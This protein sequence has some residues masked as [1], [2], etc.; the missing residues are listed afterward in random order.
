MGIVDRV[1]RNAVYLFSSNVLCRILS[2]LFFLV[3]SQKLV[4]S[5]FGK[6][7]LVLTVTSYFVILGNLGFQPMSIKEIS[8]N[9]ERARFIFLNII[10]IRFIFSLLGLVVFFIMI[11]LFNYDSEINRYFYIIAFTV[12]LTPMSDAMTAMFFAHEKM[13]APALLGVGFSILFNLTGLVVIFFEGDSSLEHLFFLSLAVGIL[14]ISGYYLLFRK[15]F[16]PIRPMLDR[17]FAV[18]IIKRTLPFG[19]L[20]FLAVIH[21]RIDI[22]MLSKIPA[23]DALDPV[24]MGLEKAPGTMSAVAYYA[25]PYKLFN[26]ASMLLDSVRLVIYPVISAHFMKSFDIV[27][28]TYYKL[29]RLTVYFFSIPLFFVAFFGSSYLITTIFSDKWGPSAHAMKILAGVFALN[30]LNI[31]VLPI[32]LNSV[33]VFRLG[34]WGILAILINVGLNLILI[35]HYSFLGAAWAT[36]ASV[37]FLMCIKLWIVKKT[38]GPS[39]SIYPGFNPLALIAVTGMFISYFVFSWLQNIAGIGGSGIARLVVLALA[40]GI[41]YLLLFRVG[42]VPEMEKNQI[43]DLAKSF[44][45]FR[46]G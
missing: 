5:N 26:S 25:I 16:F 35:P 42:A 7:N 14:G 41:Y 32:L 4:P 23:S 10:T 1:A 37:C 8:R 30:A 18:D 45:G 24:K 15:H 3:A 21:S 46:R 17:E 38:F 27:V 31:I 12:L 22:L 34:I 11:P 29:T 9:K 19:V 28:T 33:F 43:K 20:A 6:Y 44:I 36:L 13:L 39:R 40:V 2:F